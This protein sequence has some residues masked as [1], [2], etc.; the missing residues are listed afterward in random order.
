MTSLSFY[1]I[2]HTPADV[3][4]PYGC[5]AKRFDYILHLAAYVFDAF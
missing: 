3:W 1:R 5:S 4:C 2:E